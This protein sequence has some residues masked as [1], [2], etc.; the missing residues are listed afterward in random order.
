MRVGEL[1]KEDIRTIG[2]NSTEMGNFKHSMGL[3]TE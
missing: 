3:G 2:M 1:R